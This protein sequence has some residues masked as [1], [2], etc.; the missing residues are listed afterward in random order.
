VGFGQ[1]FL[2]KDNFRMD[3]GQDFPDDPV[4]SVTHTGLTQTS[5]E[6]DPEAVSLRMLIFE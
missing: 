3:W 2:G 5:V 6:N 4:G 1:V